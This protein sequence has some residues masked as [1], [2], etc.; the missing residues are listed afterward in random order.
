MKKIIILS[1]IVILILGYVFLFNLKASAIPESDVQSFERS[2]FM[3]AETLSNVDRWVA[4]NDDFALY[5]DETTSYFRVLDKRSGAIWRS[6]PD[7]RDPWETTPGK[8]ITVTAIEKQKSTLEITYFD[9]AGASTTI[10]NYKLAISHPASVLNDAGART[11]DIKYLANGFQVLYRIEDL[12]IDYLFFPKYL[13]KDVMETLEDRSILESI[14]YKGFDEET[15]LYEIT[16]YESMS[17]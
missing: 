5:L 7:E 9:K 4:E 13:P 2:G 17:S 8:T 15:G 16:A 12:E 14:A 10:N 1:L 11:Y 6:N 3:D